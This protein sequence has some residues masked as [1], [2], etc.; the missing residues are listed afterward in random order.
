VRFQGPLEKSPVT[1]RLEATYP[2]WKRNVFRY[3][4]SVPIIG[5]CLAVVFIVMF[6]ILELQVRSLSNYSKSA[7][8]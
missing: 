6:L 2:A 8:V 4:V 7:L 5:L 1:G 3:F